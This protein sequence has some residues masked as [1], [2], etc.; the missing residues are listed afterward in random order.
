MSDPG[1]RA[2]FSQC[3]I[4]SDEVCTGWATVTE[5]AYRVLVTGSRTWTDF[6]LILAEVRTLADHHPRLVIVHGAAP[7]GADMLASLAARQFG[8][9]QERH[10]AAWR[11]LGKRA[12]Y[13]RN[14]EMV[15][16]HPDECLAFLM[17]CEL[18]RCQARPPHPTHGS[19]HCAKLAEDAGI[20]VRRVHG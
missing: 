19:A 14:E 8:V 12:G 16:T 6:S 10:P 18:P 13:V 2:R 9:V 5:S 3:G 20:P 17:T 1:L 11:R 4:A 7:S 15:M